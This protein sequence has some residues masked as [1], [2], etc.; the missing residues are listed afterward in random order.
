MSLLSMKSSLLPSKYSPPVS[1]FNSVLSKMLS[2]ALTVSVLNVDADP[3]NKT[4]AL[5]REARM[6]KI[7]V[8]VLLLAAVTRMT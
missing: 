8:T 1:V 4:W 7:D 5:S 3:L 6:V 2:S